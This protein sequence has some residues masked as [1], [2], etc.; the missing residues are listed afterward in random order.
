MRR[1]L[2][3]LAC[4][5]VIGGCIDAPL[6]TP[7]SD[8]SP[9]TE[10]ATPFFDGGG[11]WEICTREWDF[12]PAARAWIDEESGELVYDN[13]FITCG[14]SYNSQWGNYFGDGLGYEAWDST[15]RAGYD[16]FGDLEGELAACPVC[17]LGEIAQ[18]LA[19]NPR[20]IQ[21]ADEIQEALDGLIRRV[22]MASSRVGNGTITQIHHIATDKNW[23]SAF[24]GGPWSPR[25]ADLFSR[26]GMSRQD[27]LNK[28]PVAMHKGPHSAAYTL[29]VFNR[30]NDAVGN[31]VGT[32]AK[33][34]LEA[35]LALIRLELANPNSFISQLL[36]LGN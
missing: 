27:P 18:R 33:E 19:S 25:F 2:L 20:F 30:L 22:V 8:T 21:Y 3:P 26:A 5:A 1:V 7:D 10:I 4:I 31:K 9:P 12:I 14:G 6:T 15:A 13:P 36:H 23:V 28:L 11:Y 24:R 16:L 34:Y 35:E 32:S 29:Y 17:R